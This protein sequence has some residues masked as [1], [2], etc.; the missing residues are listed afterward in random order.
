MSNRLVQKNSVFSQSSLCSSCYRSSFNT[1]D[2]HW[3]TIF[4]EQWL[5]CDGLQRGG[6]GIGMG[7]FN[8]TFFL[9]TL[10]YKLKFLFV[11]STDFSLGKLKKNTPISWISSPPFETTLLSQELWHFK[12]R[13]TYFLSPSIWVQN[14]SKSVFRPSRFKTWRKQ[15]FFYVKQIVKHN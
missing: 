14:K 11:Y 7:I 10:K 1:I 3:L 15:R 12:E 4:D 9:Y 6:G 13:V 8:L 2:Y 5:T